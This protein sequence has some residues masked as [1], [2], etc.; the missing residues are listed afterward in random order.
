MDV[1]SHARSTPQ[2]VWIVL[3]A[4]IQTSST[5]IPQVDILSLRINSY[6]N[7]LLLFK[8]SASIRP[9]FATVIL[10]QDVVGM[11][12]VWTNV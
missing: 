9:W 7:Y 10:T 11:T 5:A 1:K 3:L 2:L 12:K 4:N 8:A 6:P